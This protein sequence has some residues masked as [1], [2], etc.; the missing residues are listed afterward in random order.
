MGKIQEAQQNMKK[1]QEEL[2]HIQTTGESGGG[3]VKAVVNGQKKVVSIE[4]D[5]DIITKEDKKLIEDLTV[6]AINIATKKA[7][8]KAQE[9]MK[10]SI[11]GGLPNIPGFDLSNF[12]K[13]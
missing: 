5:P 8:E 10:S 9:V 13:F 11:P 12:G 2:E 6:A 7:E 4:I 3:M 1:A